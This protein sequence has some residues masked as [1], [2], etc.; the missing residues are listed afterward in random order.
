MP[1]DEELRVKKAAVSVVKALCW[2]VESRFQTSPGDRSSD[3]RRRDLP[4]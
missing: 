4:A 2:A 1:P 3:K